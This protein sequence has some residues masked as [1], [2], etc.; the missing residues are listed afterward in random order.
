MKRVK[1]MLDP[2]GSTLGKDIP[3]EDIEN[4][5]EEERR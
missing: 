5:T 3:M 4:M 2:D 1:L